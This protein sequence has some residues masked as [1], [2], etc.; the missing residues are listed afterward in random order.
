MGSVGFTTLIGQHLP[1]KTTPQLIAV[2]TSPRPG[3]FS[4]QGLAKVIA[5]V[6]GTY[7]RVELSSKRS[8]SAVRLW[9]A[10]EIGRLIVPNWDMT[11]PTMF[12]IGRDIILGE[13][14]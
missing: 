14:N 11:R 6:G 4:S 2:W 12:A 9:E 13:I 5:R 3:V 8:S 10:L 7:T 1:T